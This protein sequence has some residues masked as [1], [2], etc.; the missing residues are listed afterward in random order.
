MTFC[1]AERCFSTLK[2]VKTFLRKTLCDDRLNV[3]AMLSAEKNLV[4]DS[5]DL[6]KI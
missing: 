6:I 4:K 5:I 3:L 2:R 1:E